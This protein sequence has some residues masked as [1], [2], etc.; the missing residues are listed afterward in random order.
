MDNRSMDR[1]EIGEEDARG[2]ITVN[3]NRHMSGTRLL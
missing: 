2:L 1:V 3:N